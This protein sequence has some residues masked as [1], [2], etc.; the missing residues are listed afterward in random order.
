VVVGDKD[1]EILVI[2]IRPVNVELPRVTVFGTQFDDAAWTSRAQRALWIADTIQ[3][4]FYTIRAAFPQGPV[5]GEGP[6]GI[7]V[8][9]FTGTTEP[10]EIVTPLLTQRDGVFHRPR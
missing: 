2:K 1:Q 6:S 9:S 3:N 5:F 8:Q 10:G 7:P 4:A